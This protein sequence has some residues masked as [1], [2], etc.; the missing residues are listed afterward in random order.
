MR[1]WL[2]EY[3]TIYPKSS[4]GHYTQNLSVSVMEMLQQQ[5]F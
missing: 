4:K 3:K 1:I 5:P 2:S